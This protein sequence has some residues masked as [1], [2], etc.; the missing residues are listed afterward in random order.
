[1]LYSKS[2]MFLI[3]DKESREQETFHRMVLLLPLSALRFHSSLPFLFISRLLIDPVI[4]S[5]IR[6]HIMGSLIIER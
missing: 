4:M 3:E 1:M 2:F 5:Q 6:I